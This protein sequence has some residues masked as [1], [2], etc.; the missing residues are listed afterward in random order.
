[1][2]GSIEYMFGVQWFE[3]NSLDLVG[4][5]DDDEND[6]GALC[7]GA[8]STAVES[9]WQMSEKAQVVTARLLP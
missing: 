5:N 6:D 3:F 1:M 8:N 7:V 2:M 9:I 4:A